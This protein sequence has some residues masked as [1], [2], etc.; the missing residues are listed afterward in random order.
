MSAVVQVM[1][2]SSWE[3]QRVAA[4]C[5]SRVVTKNPQW[6]LVLLEIVEEIEKKVNICSDVI[7]MSLHLLFNVRVF[8]YRGNSLQS[9]CYWQQSV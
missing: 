7:I 5:L 1:M 9:G 8:D 2:Q 3:T 6:A 4:T